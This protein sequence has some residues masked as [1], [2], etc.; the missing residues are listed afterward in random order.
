MRKKNDDKFILEA[1]KKEYASNS[2]DTLVRLNME[3]YNTLVDMANDSVMPMSQ[4]ASKAIMYANKHLA[5]EESE[6]E[7]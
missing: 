2:R 4:I 1:K 5:Y 6:E 7:E 3:A